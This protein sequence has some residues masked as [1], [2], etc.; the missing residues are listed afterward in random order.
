MPSDILDEVKELIRR[1]WNQEPT[2]RHSIYNR[3]VKFRFSEKATKFEKN[4][5]LVLTLLGKNSRFVKTGGIFLT[6]FVA[7]LQCLDFK[8]FT[9]LMQRYI[10]SCFVKTGGRFLS[11]FVAFS[12]CLVFKSLNF[13]YV[14]V[15]SFPSRLVWSR[16]QVDFACCSAQKAH[17]LAK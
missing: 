6:N 9:T 8:L 13:S 7:F 11:N 17:K 2:Q 16:N 15:Y 1:C 12:R 3:T 10:K 4:L 14:E 5:P